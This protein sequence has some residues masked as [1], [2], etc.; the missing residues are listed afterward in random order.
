MIF[1]EQV[2]SRVMS[3]GFLIKWGI[4]YAMWP[5]ENGKIWDVGLSEDDKS[6]VSCSINILG[7][8]D[9][10]YTM[11]VVAERLKLNHRFFHKLD[12]SDALLNSNHC[13]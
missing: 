13:L 11:N 9:K 7:Q 1:K 12:G 5:H 8:R 10:I 3:L 4:L 2:S 6:C